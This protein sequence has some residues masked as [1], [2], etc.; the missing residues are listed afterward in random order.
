M[1]NL[2]YEKSVDFYFDSFRKIFIY[3]HT[4]FISSWQHEKLIYEKKHIQSI[5]LLLKTIPNDFYILKS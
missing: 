4:L 3:I 2:S 1:N 5:R